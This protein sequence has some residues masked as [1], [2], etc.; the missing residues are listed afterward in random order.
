MAGPEYSFQWIETLTGELVLISL[1]T[2][3]YPGIDQKTQTV[4][5]DNA[6]SLPDGSDSVRF[7]RALATR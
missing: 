2:S 5:G 7:I 3:R 6:G 4:I 1:V